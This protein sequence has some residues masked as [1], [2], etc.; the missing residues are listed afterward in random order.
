MQCVCES[1]L[2]C[3]KCVRVIVKV[4]E[5]NRP[6]R[7]VT[8]HRTVLPVNRAYSYSYYVHGRS[9]AHRAVSGGEEV[10]LLTPAHRASVGLITIFWCGVRG[11]VFRDTGL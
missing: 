1:V 5:I 3:S 11:A 8:K 6:V 7:G 9:T 10:H 4:D 2:G